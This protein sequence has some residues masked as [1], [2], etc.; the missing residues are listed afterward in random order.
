MTVVAARARRRPSSAIGLPGRVRSDA[1]TLR[2]LGG[3]GEARRVAHDVVVREHPGARRADRAVDAQRVGDDGAEGRGIPRRLEVGEVER[4]VHLVGP[5][6]PRGL[7]GGREPRLGAQGAVA[8]VLGDE[9]VPVAVDLVDAVLTPVGHVV[10]VA[11]HGPCLGIGRVVGKALGLDEPVRH[12]DAEAVDTAVEPEAQHAAELGAH[13]LVRPV[14]VGLRRV[15]QV[16]VPLAER[17]VGL[18]DAGP[19]G[20]A[21]DGLPVVRRHVAGKSPAVAEEVAGA[22]A[23]ARRRRESLLEPRVLVGRVVRDQID[24]DPDAALVRL[25][26]HLV[27]VGQRAEER[28]DVAVVRDVVAGILLRRALE[29]AQPQG[30]DAEGC[31]VVE[32]RRDARQVADAV[33]ASCRRTSAG[34]SGR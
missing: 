30:V 29:G 21:E 22:L 5:H 4:L 31:E 32:A 18:D 6:P 1:V 11:A 3:Q 2:V 34:R 27:E 26:E 12:I 16:Q 33:A 23:A 24:D 19:C 17:A 7:L 14:E 10:G 15:E 28:I 9:L 8:G 13:L 25:R 20:S